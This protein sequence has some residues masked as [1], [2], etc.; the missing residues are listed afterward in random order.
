MQRNATQR[1]VHGHT[2]AGG[3][4]GGHLQ[5]G[6]T[7]A[8]RARAQGARHRL[9]QRQR[10]A[11]SIMLWE[12]GCMKDRTFVTG[13][14]EQHHPSLLAADDTRVPSHSITAFH[15]IVG[16]WFSWPCQ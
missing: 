12:G 14:E 5:R 9:S 2:V 11:V 10:S 6:G 16:S 13:T 15:H 3:G 7:R 4:A 8:V 1:L